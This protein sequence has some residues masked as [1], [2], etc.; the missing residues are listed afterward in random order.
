[1]PELDGNKAALD[2]RKEKKKVALAILY[3]SVDERTLYKVM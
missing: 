3:A 1:M 2:G